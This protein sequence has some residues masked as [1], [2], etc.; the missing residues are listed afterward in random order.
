MVHC[1][2]QWRSRIQNLAALN[3][4]V[5][6]TILQFAFHY[7]LFSVYFLSCCNCLV[8]T[9]IR[10]RYCEVDCWILN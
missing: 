6:I 2:S 5:H 1:Q 10:A 4:V 9:K 8:A 3:L 7:S